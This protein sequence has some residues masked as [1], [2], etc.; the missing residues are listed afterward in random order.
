VSLIARERQKQNLAP[1]LFYGCERHRDF[2]D[3]RKE[4]PKDPKTHHRH[5]SQKTKPI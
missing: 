3:K 5:L 4:N 1:I 2:G